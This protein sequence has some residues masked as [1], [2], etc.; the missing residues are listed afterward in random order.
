MKAAFRGLSLATPSA[1]G[2]DESRQPDEEPAYRRAALLLRG[3]A[4]AYVR[5][6]G[7]R[8]SPSYTNAF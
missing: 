2:L 7:S 5:A 4:V 6:G 8:E 1:A 3:E